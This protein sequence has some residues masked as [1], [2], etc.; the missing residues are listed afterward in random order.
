[1]VFLRLFSPHCCTGPKINFRT[2]IAYR[3]L[4]NL[5]K[6]TPERPSAFRGGKQFDPTVK[7]YQANTGYR[8]VAFLPRTA[9]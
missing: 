6:I 9:S 8:P 4:W 1:M 2:V 3:K 5:G 7:G